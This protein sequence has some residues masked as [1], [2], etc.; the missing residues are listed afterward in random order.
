[1][2]RSLAAEPACHQN[3]HL[4]FFRF[5]MVRRNQTLLDHLLHAAVTMLAGIFRRRR[6]ELPAEITAN[7]CDDA[8][9]QMSRQQFAGLVAA[10]FRQEGYL[11]VER[12]G[13]R[14]DG[15]VDLEM[16]LGRDRYLVQCRQW[17]MTRVG[18]EVVRDLFGAMRAERA[19]GCFI[20]TSGSF[21]DDARG[22]ATGRA[23]RLVPVDSLRRMMAGEIGGDEASAATDPSGEISPVC[24]QCGKAMISRL[25]QRGEGRGLSFWG[26]SGYP[27]CRGVRAK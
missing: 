23:I 19:A 26:C 27:V 18:I 10:A 15:G 21:T 20:V 8:L 11:V 4:S 12:G 5:T 6:R 25:A 2:T 9:E 16:Y 17:R 7:S 22:F 13:R 24:P 1:M 14:S 3:I